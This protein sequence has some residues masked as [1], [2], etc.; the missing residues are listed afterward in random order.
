MIVINNEKDCVGCNA[1]TQRC[2]VGCITMHESAEGFLYPKVDIERCV[3]CHLCEKVCPIINRADTRKPV[4]AYGAYNNDENI[5]LISSS[6]GVFFALAT[7]IINSGGVVFGACYDEHFDV[8]HDYAETCDEAKKFCGSKY[9]QSR[10]GNAFLKIEQY[11]KSGRKVMFTGTPCQVAGL[12]LFLRKSYGDRLLLVEVIC[13]GVPSPLVWRKYLYS[14]SRAQNIGETNEISYPSSV[15]THA[16]KSLVTSISFRDKRLGWEKYGLTVRII[17]QKDNNHQK[18]QTDVN[19]SSSD[20]EFFEPH[21]KNLFMQCFL[22]DI[23]LRPS[24]FECPARCGRSGA[25]ITL[26][27]F[28]HVDTLAPQMVNDRKGLSLV[29]A[30]S[31][32][33]KESLKNCEKLSLIPTS[34]DVA[35]KSN[36]ALIKDPLKPTNYKSFRK[37]VASVKDDI[38]PVMFNAVRKAKLPLFIRIRRKFKRM[39]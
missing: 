26:G 30:Y 20:I 10:I 5:R 15:A 6:G 28:W 9:V 2:P 8:I 17:A 32:Q 29:L 14:I 36:I 27:D 3:N 31:E 39:I 22:K 1:C 18:S 24:C 13:H 21:H 12:R 25:D 7:Y 37:S 35:L 19:A 16:N 11:L 38:I 34:Y 4:E 23:S 33:G